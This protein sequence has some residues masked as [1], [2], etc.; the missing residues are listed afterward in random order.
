[1]CNQCDILFLSNDRYQYSASQASQQAYRF[2]SIA[3]TL[4]IDLGLH[5]RPRGP[6][7]HERIV[8]SLARDIRAN[9]TTFPKFWSHDARRA[10]LGTYVLSTLLGLCPTPLF[11]YLTPSHQLRFAISQRQHF[12][13]LA[14]SGGMCSITGRERAV[15]RKC[16]NPILCTTTT[17]LYGGLRYIRLW[18]SG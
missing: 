9:P 11:A 4:L 16:C 18:L 15:R 5:R 13:T 3:V 17:H 1:M 8:D 10:F 2:S 12:Q 14:I 7:N 6:T